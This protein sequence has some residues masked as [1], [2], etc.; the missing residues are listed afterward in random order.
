MLVL[1]PGL[2]RVDISLKHYMTALQS[3]SLP[4][5]KQIPND[6]ILTLI[7]LGRGLFKQT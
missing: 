3:T 4:D 6:G 7:P 5:V 2:D 1:F